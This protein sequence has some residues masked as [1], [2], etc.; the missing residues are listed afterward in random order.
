MPATVATT[1][2]IQVVTLGSGIILARSLGP[3]DR[4]VAA[5][6]MLWP[7]LLASIG[8]LGIAEGVTFFSGREA[9]GPSTIL[10]SAL[11]LGAVQ[12]IVLLLLGSLLLPLFLAGKAATLSAAFYYL[13]IIPLYPLTL[14][15]I[16]VLQGRMNL[17]AFNV[18]RLSV[19]V[20]YTGFLIALW[21]QKAVT[22]RSALTASLAATAVTA[23]LS[24]WLIARRGHWVWRMDSDGLRA[25]IAFGAKLHLGNVA[26]IIASKLDIVVLTIFASAQALGIYVVATA[27]GTVVGLVP[28]AIAMVLYPRFVRL[29]TA[30]RQMTLSRLLLVGITVTFSAGPVMVIALPRLIPFIFGK[31]FVSAV[32]V[33]A[34]LV[35]GYLI[36]GY[37][38]MLVALL[39]GAGQPLRASTGEMIGLILFAGCLPVLTGRFGSAGTATALTI[40]AAATLVWM[41]IQAGSATRLSLPRLWSLWKADVTWL[42]ASA[43]GR[44]KA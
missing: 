32:P 6:A 39:R 14:Y 30:D 29:S 16:S 3:S 44:R 28:G 12:T 5:A 26:T 21:T 36:R 17:W 18:A 7:T 24:F 4:G 33:A 20:A 43:R 27:V 1:L 37:N 19:H 23:M 40:A 10:T 8:G 31:A 34:V 35:V 41:V 11:A 25:L 15:P 22:V 2:L 38:G 42:V 9:K 13:L